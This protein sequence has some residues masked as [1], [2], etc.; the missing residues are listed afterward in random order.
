MIR[1][2]CIGLVVGIALAVYDAS[3][4]YGQTPPACTH[5]HVDANGTPYEHSHDDADA[6][7]GGC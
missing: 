4:S 7:L 3:Q 6:H 5:V 1:L 2:L